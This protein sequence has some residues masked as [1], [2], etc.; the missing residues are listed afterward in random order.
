MVLINIYLAVANSYR[1]SYQFIKRVVPKMLTSHTL[2]EPV[3]GTMHSVASRQSSSLT[4]VVAYMKDLDRI[5]EQQIVYTMKIEKENKKS[6]S[7]DQQ[8][9]VRF[10]L[11]F[12]SLFINIAPGGKRTIAGAASENQKR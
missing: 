5:Q 12:N 10:P 4:N 8:I 7:L 2:E 3:M 9:R 11:N 1:Y 6:Q